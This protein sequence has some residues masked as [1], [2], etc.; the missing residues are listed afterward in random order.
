METERLLLV[1]D[2]PA[3]LELMTHVLYLPKDILLQELS[4]RVTHALR[5]RSHLAEAIESQVRRSDGAVLRGALDQIGLRSVLRILEMEGQS[6]TLLLRREASDETARFL[7]RDGHVLAVRIAD[8]DFQGTVETAAE[9]L[10]WP[11]GDFEFMAGDVDVEDEVGES[12]TG[13]LMMAARILDESSSGM[14][15]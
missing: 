3:F 10:A 5:R 12:A 1:D 15:S 7:L 2:D 8:K 13:L 9:I 4:G 11:R 6:E 14:T